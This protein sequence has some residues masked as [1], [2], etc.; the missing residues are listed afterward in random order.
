LISATAIQT[1]QNL[2]KHA[3]VA[4]EAIRRRH[5]GRTALQNLRHVAQHA[6][7]KDDLSN[8]DVNL[9]TGRARLAH[10]SNDLIHLRLQL[11]NAG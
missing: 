6:I 1:H 9:C 4:G 7:C 8:G 5:S 2:T 11:R 3:V 10:R